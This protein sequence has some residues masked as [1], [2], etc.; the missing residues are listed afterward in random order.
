MTVFVLILGIISCERRVMNDEDKE[1]IDNKFS[2]E[3]IIGGSN[4][5][6]RNH[7]YVFN[8]DSFLYIEEFPKT[9]DGVKE[10]YK[11]EVFEESSFEM[12]GH[13]LGD[14]KYV[15]ASKNIEFT[16]Y[17]NTKEDAKLQIV[18]IYT[19]LYQCPNIQIIGM[20]STGIK[21]LI[22][23]SIKYNKEGNNLRIVT[24]DW[25]YNIRIDI[26]NDV[27]IGYLI[28]ENI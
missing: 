2:T 10:E 22:G 4:T 7:T 9:I 24:D 13:S 21:E 6:D 5:S 8:L 27:V 1:V 20:T 14:Y 25:M 11:D 3:E 17:G 26:E 12:G 23:N 18:E 28:A 19:P 15:L 16:F